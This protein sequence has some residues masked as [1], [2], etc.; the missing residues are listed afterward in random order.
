MRGIGRKSRP[1]LRKT[2]KDS[3]VSSRSKQIAEKQSLME[4][5][6]PL[7][8]VAEERQKVSHL[9]TRMNERV[10]L[11]ALVVRPEISRLRRPRLVS[12]PRTWVAREQA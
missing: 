5:K 10:A 8:S 1:N 11:A 9:Q 12:F 3:L 2:I 7:T 4:I 6:N